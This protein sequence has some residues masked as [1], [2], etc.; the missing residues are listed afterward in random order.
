MSGVLADLD[1]PDTLVQASSP[2][3]SGARLG[4]AALLLGVLLLALAALL[5]VVSVQ[6]YL[7]VPFFDVHDWIGQVFVVERTH[8][9]LGY[10]W[11]PH[12]AER[13]PWARAVE[14][15]DVE[16]VRGR[17]PSFL[18]AGMAAWLI[19]CIP[20]ALLL[21]RSSLSR[22]ARIIV[23][24]LA[25]MLST[26]VSLAEDF[27]FPVFSVYLM[28]A[29]PALGAAALLQTGPQAGLRSWTFWAAM[30]LAA[31]ASDGNA[32]GLAI[33][34][35]LL[36]TAGLQRRGREQVFALL[37]CAAVCIAAIESGLGAP[38]ASLGRDGGSAGAH[39]LKMAV[40]FLHFVGLPWTQ[41]T[42]SGLALAIALTTLALAFR[43]SFKAARWTNDAPTARLRGTAL[44]LILFGLITAGLATIGRVDELPTAVVPTRYTPF[45]T[46]LQL[47]VLLGLAEQIGAF[48]RAAWLPAT[49][50]A[51][52]SLGL[53]ASDLHDVR[54]LNR[55]AHR[56]RA[57]S[58]AF[59]RSFDDADGRLIHPRPLF[60]ADIRRRLAA[61]GLPH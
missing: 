41:E 4:I 22:P 37:V 19:G 30:A 2:P 58:A 25:V 31:A 43:A 45:A 34:P 27:A 53:F 15:L 18:I 33:W 46:L 12:T 29:G 3:P 14:W 51:V 35:A 49:I 44:A 17:A 40:Y 11:E 21:T 8:D 28:V 56:V 32:A 54:S 48:R 13:I 9:W 20:F 7:Y 38:S 36:I 47:G 61:R 57:A 1:A 50:A 60:A 55:A 16:V 26:Q 59:D 24:L 42:H 10:L 5:T 52:L 23:L 6:D 39:L